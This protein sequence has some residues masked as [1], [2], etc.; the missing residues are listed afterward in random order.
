MTGNPTQRWR[1]V[2]SEASTGWGGQERRIMA[3]LEGFKRRGHDVWLLA[4]QH[5]S[6]F[7][8]AKVAGISVEP[9]DFTRWK[10]PFGVLKV[11]RWINRIRPHIVNPHSSRDGWLV[12]L[13]ARIA[14]VPF[15]V[16]TRHFDVPVSS[17]QMSGFV[18]SKLADHVL[19]TSP[20]VTEHF[21]ELFRLPESRVS[22]LSTGIDTKLFS[23]TGAKAEFIP[24]LADDSV[25]LIGMVSIIRLAKGHETLLQAAAQL[26]AEGFKAR[27]VIVGE[28]PYADVIRAKMKALQLESLFTF[29]GQRDDVPA[30]LRSLSILV[31]PSLHEGIP[32]TALQALATKTPVVASNVGGIPSVI[33]D[34]ETGR[35][36]PP[37]DPAALAL[38]I[39]STLQDTAATQRMCKD[40]RILVEK[41]HSL[42]GM[43]DKL[44]ALYRRHL[45]A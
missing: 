12:G 9:I 28:G 34:G 23:Q 4:P 10:F 27:Y 3:E 17:K 37:G 35:L 15:V 31:I 14:R 11:V 2:H 32:Q 1:I 33:R 16:R 42:E 40:G 44:E 24:D 25:P 38:A 18:Y 21:R 6:I 26:R 8:R 30:I 7:Q 36:V 22:T 39:K 43:L 45:P 5:S 41:E 13:A 29:V 19:T 20:K